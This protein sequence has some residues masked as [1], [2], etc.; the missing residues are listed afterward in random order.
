MLAAN[1]MCCMHFV[2]GQMEI[3]PEEDINVC[4]KFHDNHSNSVVVEIVT[5]VAISRATTLV[6]YKQHI[7]SEFHSANI[8]KAALIQVHR[9]ALST[10]GESNNPPFMTDLNKWGIVS[11][12]VMGKCNQIH[13][14]HWSYLSAGISLFT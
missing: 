13:N 8:I 11:S 14:F 9:A 7:F 12:W 3:Y 1:V 5:D 6:I 2:I 10:P 4:T